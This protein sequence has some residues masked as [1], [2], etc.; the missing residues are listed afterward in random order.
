MRRSWLSVALVVVA[1]VSLVGVLPVLAAP[2]QGQIVHV[3]R[4]GETLFSIARRYGVSYLEIA[5]F[6]GIANPS[7]IY[8]GQR[9]IIPTGAPAPAPSSGVHV[10][11]R[12]ETLF[13]IALR[14]GVDIYSLARVNGIVNLNRIYVGQRLTIPGAAPAPK[15][16]SSPAPSVVFPGPWIGEYFG[17]AD[18]GDGPFVT[19]TDQQINF[20]W[21]YGPPAGG[22]PVNHFSVRWTGTFNLDEGTYRLYAKIDDGVRVFVDGVLVI[23]GWR[24]GGLRTY[25]TDQSLAAGDHTFVVEY[26][27]GVGVAQVF[28]WYK[29]ISGPA[30][31]ATPKGTPVPQANI[32]TAQFFNNKDLQGSPA[33]TRQDGFIGF[34]WG[35]GS[36]A[37]E[38]W[39]DGF[40]ARWVTKLKLQT[41]HYRFCTMADD[42]S[43][44]WVGSTLVLDRWQANNGTAYCGEYWAKTG[45]YDV[46]VEYFEDGGKALIYMWWEP[47]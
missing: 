12:G 24:A 10:V 20:D 46:R 39:V 30:P 34:D 23:N 22:M 45:T 18:L 5:R 33:L 1:V 21:A 26:F 7:R 41:D 9:L 4:R 3:V 2:D 44:I 38:V 15:P 25:T 37:P 17:N 43:R 19:R 6:N 31:T 42:G 47:H 29:K 32:W 11:R 16:P 35:T 14:Y 13:S 40:S 36:P 27:D 8:V 28:F